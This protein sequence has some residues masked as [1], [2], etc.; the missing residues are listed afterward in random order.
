MDHQASVYGNNS[1]RANGQCEYSSTQLFDVKYGY[2]SASPSG[3]LFELKSVD[4]V[5]L[6]YVIR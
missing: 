1:W 5:A 4:V 2:E 6:L 3:K